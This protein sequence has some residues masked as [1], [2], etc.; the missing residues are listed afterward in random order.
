MAII[1]RIIGIIAL[2]SGGVGLNLTQT[3]PVEASTSGYVPSA[4]ADQTLRFTSAGYMLA[5]SP[6]DVMIASG[7]QM[8]KT[9]FVNA[10]RV[11]PR[12]DGGLKSDTVDGKAAPLGTVIYDNLWDGVKLVYGTG[13]GAIA[14]STYYLN[15]GDAVKNIHLRYNRPV[16]TDDDGNLLVTYETGT[17]KESPPVAWQ[18]I[19]NSQKPVEVSWKQYSQNEVGFCLGEYITGQ[20]VVIDPWLA[21]IGSNAY[22]YSFPNDIAMDWVGN[23]YITGYSM[24]SWGSPIRA[25]SGSSDDFV[26][27]PFV[28]KLDSKGNPLWN[29]FLGAGDGR[30]KSIAVDGWGNAYIT[31]QSFNSWGTPVRAITGNTGDAFA[32][33]LDTNGNLQWNTFLGGSE[34][35]ESGEGIAVDGF[36]NNIY[37]TGASL[38]SWGTPVKPFGGF[39]NAFVA[40]LDSS[41]VLQWNTF[42]G[43]PRDHSTEGYGIAIDWS[44]N[45]YISGL[46]NANFGTPLM[47]FSG[48]GDVFV[49]KFNSS[50]ILQWNTFMIGGGFLDTRCDV[51]ADAWGNVYLTGLSRPTWGTAAVASAKL[52]DN[53]QPFA[54]KFNTSGTLQWNKFFDSTDLTDVKSITVDMNGNLFIIGQSGVIPGAAFLGGGTASAVKLDSS[55]TKKWRTPLGGTGEI[56]F[57]SGA[58]SSTPGNGIVVDASGNSFVTGSGGKW[59]NITPVS[60]ASSGNIFVV[61]IDPDGSVIPPKMEVDGNL[62]WIANGDTLASSSDCTDFGSVDIQAGKVVQTFTIKNTGGADLKLSGSP[63]VA[64]SGPNASNFTVTAQPALLIKAGNSST[65]QVTFDHSSIGLK[66]ATISIANNYPPDNPYTFAVQGRGTKILTVSG[67]TAN[68]KV[69]D[70]TTTATLNT[71]SATLAGIIGNDA[72]TLVTGSAVGSFANGIVGNGKTVTVSGLTLSGADAVNYTLTQP[73]TTANIT[74]AASTITLASSANPSSSGQPISFTATVSASAGTPTGTVAI[75]IG[76][77]ITGTVNLNNGQGTFSTSGLMTGTYSVTAIYSGDTNYTSVTSTAVSQVIGLAGTTTSLTGPQGS[78]N[79]GKTAAFTI[80]VSSSSGTPT[81]IVTVKDGETVLG[82]ANL[83]K[84]VAAYSTAALSAGTHS[85]T[86]VYNGD[87]NYITSTSAAVSQLINKVSTTTNLTGPKGS[88]NCGQPITF[89]ARVSALSGTPSGVVTIQEGD[90]VLG[91]ASLLDGQAAYTTSDLSVGTHT[92]TAIYGGDTNYKSAT[93]AAVSQI[94]DKASATLTVAPDINPSVNNQTISF[95]ATVSALSGT[96]TG[97]VT[98]VDGFN[99]LDTVNLSNGQA[100]Y[101]TSGLSVGTHSIAAVYMGDSNYK[102]NISNFV[103]QVVNQSYVYGQTF[104]FTAAMS[105]S[106]STPTG[107][108]TIKDGDAVLGTASLNNGQA[109]YSTSSLEVGTHS[110]SAVYDGNTPY[111]KSN[112]SPLTLVVIKANT[113]TTLTLPPA[114]A[115]Q[116]QTI[117][118]TAVVSATAPGV[119]TPTGTV[120]FMDGSTIL[121]TVFIIGDQAVFNASQFGLG[122]HAISATY[123]GDVHFVGST[124]TLNQTIVTINNT[125]R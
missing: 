93:S 65:F 23:I 107:A 11:E 52:D 39:I 67:I 70:G 35:A 6:Q 56:D 44:N 68:N 69:Y 5:F 106:G 66:T 63:S 10:N 4:Q 19:D 61:Q 101:S 118:F 45:I 124:A 112:S 17:L 49:A 113:K 12:A 51:A 97:T 77:T 81:G 115:L 53:P 14:K 21:L 13:E 57:S 83:S 75:N 59:Q 104:T 20:P 9:V 80:T 76:P 100:V 98:F 105:S 31:G 87:T 34:H 32:A 27:N 102:S 108:V 43:V 88:I 109:T 82:S 116:D 86:V 90:T 117:S 103:S 60:S 2:V 94:I 7:S 24:G 30:G 74:A 33:K 16:K 62:T 79:Y 36:G 8:L 92:I 48:E 114:S 3:S 18:I 110:I 122:N 72:V 120:T 1:A 111:R 78:L 50:G 55:G 41:G 28:V 42:L 96:P 95:T 47:A 26:S 22:P 119:G 38:S 64:I 71:G 84:G 85:I 123:N 89:T 40:K 15:S 37:V 121:G 125:S 99:P 25:F 91:T 46:S 29:T 73:T 54:A 58:S